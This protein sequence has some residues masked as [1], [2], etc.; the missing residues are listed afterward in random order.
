M[1]LSDFRNATKLAAKHHAVLVAGVVVVVLV[2]G[3]NNIHYNDCT[4]ET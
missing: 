2:D 1:F 4:L 3:K